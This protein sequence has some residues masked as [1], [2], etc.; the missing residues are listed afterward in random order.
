MAREVLHTWVCGSYVGRFERDTEVEKP[1]FLYT[2][3]AGTDLSLSIPRSGEMN[4]NAPRSFLEALLPENPAARRSIQK[5]TGA[6]TAGYWDLLAAIG[7]DLQGGVVIHSEEDGPGLIEPYMFRAFDGDVADRILQIKRGGTGFGNPLIPPRFSLAGAQA[8]FALAVTAFG[9]FW[10]DSATPSTHILK[11]AIPSHAGLEQIEVA[12]LELARRAGIEAPHAT[13]AEFAG[14][15]AFMIERFDRAVRA[16][17]IATRIHAEDMTQ[18]LG[19]PVDEKYQVHTDDIAALLRK[20]T[21]NDE[22]G[23]EFYRQYAF[24]AIIGNSDAHGKNY[25]IVQGESGIRLSPLYDAIPI[26]LFPDYSQSLAMP[27]GFMDHYLTVTPAD[28]RESAVDAGLDPDRVTAL[29]AEVASAVLENLDATIGQVD[30]A[31]VTASAL[32]NIRRS[33]EQQ[34]ALVD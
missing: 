11:P 15:T 12:T 29:V 7:G 17:G 21:G 10:P 25:S 22:L 3:S 30:S 28:W 20:H 2:E 32:G 18:A 6:T 19:R 8:K 9:A 34:G 14:E 24:N 31:R 27:V 23:Y 4:R 16:D 13:Q 1:R 26:G 5:L 33:A